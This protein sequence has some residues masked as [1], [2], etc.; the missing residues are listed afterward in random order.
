M[1]HPKYPRDFEGWRPLRKITGDKYLVIESPNGIFEA[2]IH[3]KDND[4]VGIKYKATGI[5]IYDGN[6]EMAKKMGLKL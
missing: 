6:I 4:V 3:I 1:S 5:D 2:C